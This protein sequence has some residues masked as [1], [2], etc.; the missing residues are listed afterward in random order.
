MKKFRNMN[1]VV[2]LVLALS[3]VGCPPYA[4]IITTPQDGASFESGEEVRFAGSAM[5]F[6]DGELIDS[7]LIWTSDKDSEIGE[8]KECEKIDLSMGIHTI[9][10][11]ATNSQG[12]RAKAT[13]TITVG[14]E[15]VNTTTT[16]TEPC[17]ESY[18]PPKTQVGSLILNNNQVNEDITFFK[19]GFSA[20]TFVP[21]TGLNVTA[22]VAI[23][24]QGDIYVS[25]F[26][27]YHVF[28]DGTFEKIANAGAFYLT[29]GSDGCL[30]TDS[31]ENGNAIIRITPEGSESILAQNL[32][33]RIGALRNLAGSPDGYI[34]ADA[35]YENENDGLKMIRVHIE[36]G[37]IEIVSDMMFGPKVFDGS[38]NLFVVQGNYIYRM[39][40]LGEFSQEVCFTY[41]EDAGQDFYGLIIDQN[42]DFL[43]TEIPKVTSNEPEKFVNQLGTRVFRIERSTGNLYTLAEGLYGTAGL[44]QDQDGNVYVAE[45][46]S[47]ALGK[48]S[49]AGEV[50]TLIA[51]NLLANPMDII[52]AKDGSLVISNAETGLL[53]KAAPTSSVTIEMTPYFMGLNLFAGITGNYA[54]TSI[55]T[56]SSGTIY[57]AEYAPDIIRTMVSKISL[58]DQV[59]TFT[60]NPDSPNGLAVDSEGNVW[61]SNAVSGVIEKYD[62]EGTLLG[63]TE[64][65]QTP[66]D[67]AWYNGE[68][69]VAEYGGDKI[70]KVGSDFSL[71]TFVAGIDGPIDLAFSSS[72][73]MVITTSGTL[74]IVEGPPGET[75]EAEVL[76]SNSPMP[77]VFQ[78]VVF[79]DGYLYVCLN[80]GMVLKISRPF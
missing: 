67:I 64:A 3:L 79:Y 41:P 13:I 25:A 68:L 18:A 2:L 39:S 69:Y 59:S 42:G 60:S 57:V 54:Y 50:S 40:T 47:S 32:S 17:G 4:V 45:M 37:Q 62:Q 48:T 8:G 76:A 28:P 11:T 46:T 26:G 58:D 16:T 66:S 35:G 65:L 20:W 38:G 71:S 56:D 29:V 70:R 19:T 33:P 78:G 61:I 74:Y 23:T 36:T 22:G 10:L 77:A 27:T 31:P 12:E 7:S 5:D 63:S 21:Q 43:A 73:D 55:D 52:F 34:Y 14:E 75:G 53:V 24:E 1:P 6:Q 80:N 51:G 49:A 9:T 30:Y 44:A 72:G 15:A